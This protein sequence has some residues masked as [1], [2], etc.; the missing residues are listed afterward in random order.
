MDGISS[1][2][3]FTD[4]PNTTLNGEVF[5]EGLGNVVLCSPEYK[6]ND[7]DTSSA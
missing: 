1:T 2:P 7:C 4:S 3:A 5:K 6:C